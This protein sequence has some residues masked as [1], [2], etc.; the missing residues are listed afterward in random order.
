MSVPAL[1]CLVCL[2]P[3]LA[4]V[5]GP[6]RLVRRRILPANLSLPASTRRADYL[7]NG[8]TADYGALEDPFP[9]SQP[10]AL[11]GHDER[12]TD[13]GFMDFLA[14]T[15]LVNLLTLS[16][17]IPFCEFSDLCKDS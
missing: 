15:K 4:L 9:Y 5:P 8:L 17:P 1:L 2:S 6:R 10:A 14:G 16:L 12:Q 13:M 7:G 11:A 3:G